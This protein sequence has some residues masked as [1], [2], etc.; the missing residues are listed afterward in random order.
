MMLYKELELEAPSRAER[1]HKKNILVIDNDGKFNGRYAEKHRI[2][3]ARDA[4]SK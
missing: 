1:R 4:I 3:S 2:A